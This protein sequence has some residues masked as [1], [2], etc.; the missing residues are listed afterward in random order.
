MPDSTAHNNHGNYKQWDTGAVNFATFVITCIGA[1][2]AIALA[3]IAIWQ[4]TLMRWAL[5]ETREDMRLE[6]RPYVSIGTKEGKM[7]G[8]LEAFPKASIELFFRNGGRLPALNFNVAISNPEDTQPLQHMGKLVN[9]A[10]KKLLLIAGGNI[11]S[12]DSEYRAI[13][14]DWIPQSD[15]ELAKQRLKK[16]TVHGLFEY[17]DEFGGYD[18][19]EFIGIYKPQ[20]RELY[21]VIGDACEYVYPRRPAGTES[22]D[23]R[24]PCDTAEE[25]KEQRDYIQERI[26]AARPTPTPPTPK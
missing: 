13:F 7:A 15:V 17:C 5:D 4:A 9:R 2:A 12:G 22:F 20:I 21:L 18:C 25:Q 6:Q 11:V 19:R 1:I 26:A 16:V 23:F 10:A 14:D 24:P 3:A 8:F